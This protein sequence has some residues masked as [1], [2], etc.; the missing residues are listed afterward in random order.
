MHFQR[1]Y[2]KS[3]ID[4]LQNDEGFKSLL[5]YPESLLCPPTDSIRQDTLIK[6]GQKGENIIKW[7]LPMTYSKNELEA[8]NLTN[9]YDVNVYL[10]Q[11]SISAFQ[12]NREFHATMQ[13]ILGID[14]KTGKNKEDT[15]LYRAGPIKGMERCRAKAEN[16]YSHRHFPTTASIADFV[17]CSIVF[18]GGFFCFFSFSLSAHPLSFDFFSDCGECVNAIE[19]LQSAAK[20]K[21][22]PITAIARVKNMFKGNKR[23]KL[24]LYSYA[25]LKL[26]V[27]FEKNGKSMICEVQFLLDFMIFAKKLGHSIYE[28]QRNSEFIK[29]VYKLQTLFD[30]PWEELKAIAL[31]NDVKSL[32]NWLVYHRNVDFLVEE[33]GKD[34]LVHALAKAG[35]KKGIE[36]LLSAFRNNEKKKAALFS[37][38]NHNGKTPVEI[39]VR[40]NRFET[41]KVY[42][43]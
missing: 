10:G 38:K 30:N 23:E 8:F 42:F 37:L 5:E 35:S 40:N 12:I 21:K 36:V 2:L 20:S 4:P 7:P 11:L 15:M 31:R 22:T 18:S 25:D 34:T 3:K 26:N 13:E 27:L 14:V 24:G 29:N 1:D 39:A 6:E 33:N 32:G 19:K 43:V 28:I 16:D 41:F 9:F 17:R